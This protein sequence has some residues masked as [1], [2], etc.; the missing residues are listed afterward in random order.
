[1]NGL[2]GTPV[3]Y[4]FNL[5]KRYVEFNLRLLPRPRRVGATWMELR[6]PTYSELMRLSGTRMRI[7]SYSESDSKGDRLS[8]A[9]VVSTVTEGTRHYST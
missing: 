4:E 1:M 7:Y 5:R 6:R 8:G 3:K 9:S 2:D